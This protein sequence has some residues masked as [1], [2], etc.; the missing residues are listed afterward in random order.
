MTAIQLSS[1]GEQF[2]T[3]SDRQPHPRQ[4]VLVVDDGQDVRRLKGAVP[5]CSGQHV[6]SPAVGAI[7]REVLC[8]L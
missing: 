8:G 6:D 4:R 5:G 7:A 3:S 2:E 1:A